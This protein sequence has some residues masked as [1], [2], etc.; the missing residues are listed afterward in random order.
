ML[1]SSGTRSRRNPDNDRYLTFFRNFDGGTDRKVVRSMFVYLPWS[2][3]FRSY[4]H[5][6][7]KALFLH[8]PLSTQNEWEE[9][10]AL[11]DDS[12]SSANV[13][14][15]GRWSWPLIDPSSQ[16]LLIKDSPEHSKR[17]HCKS[18]DD[19]DK[20][21]SRAYIWKSSVESVVTCSKVS[22][23]PAIIFRRRSHRMCSKTAVTAVA[24]QGR[25]GQTVLS[26]LLWD[27][28]ITTRDDACSKPFR[29][30]SHLVKHMMDVHFV[31]R[32]SKGS[33]QAEA[34]NVTRRVRHSQVRVVRRAAVMERSLIDAS[35][36]DDTQNFYFSE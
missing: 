12:W 24:R 26:V 2:A 27:S 29:R 14:C 17:H 19:R 11:Q 34:F 6:W 1:Q 23:S 18:S 28:E 31:S 30:G 13:S 7:R 22:L 10:Q 3:V 32:S 36:T 9:D 4:W 15:I 21:T 16:D 33:L 25:E 8:R 20:L 35:V 5:V